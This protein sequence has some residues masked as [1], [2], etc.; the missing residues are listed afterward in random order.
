MLVFGREP[1]CDV[2]IDHPTISARHARLVRV[3]GGMVLEDLGSTNGTF[4]AGQRITR[5]Q[6]ALGAD[7]RIGDVLLPWGD[8]HVASFARKGS[9]SGTMMMSQVPRT[10]QSAKGAAAASTT[11][12][13]SIGVK[14]LVGFVGGIGL[15]I[16]ALAGV[17][18]LST[19][20]G[21]TS[22]APLRS[23]ATDA[24]VHGPEVQGTDPASVMRRTRAPAI[25][26]AMDIADPITRNTAVKLAAGEDG[27]FHVEQVASLWTFVRG[28][29]RYVNDP[30]G[31]E[32]FAKASET[33]TNE[34]AGDCD[35]FAILLA[36]MITAIGGEA[37]VVVMSSP[38][39][40]H[41][42]AEA[43]IRM[44]PAEVASRLATYYRRKWDPYL[45]RQRITR[46]HYRSTEACPVWLNLDWNA[47][48]PGGPYENEQWAV[49]I[50]SDG[51]ST[52]LPP[53]R[54]DAP[55]SGTPT[56]TAQTR[57]DR[58]GAAA[59]AGAASS[60]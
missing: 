38:E 8:P 58:R 42:Y 44:D 25:A 22:S 21:A 53:G 11:A 37:R 33:I 45:G 14:R 23:D 50:A 59:T 35:D 56:S 1:G 15:G 34:Y 13:V 51:A 10:A 30:R 12:G 24:A 49:A 26:A 48:V 27:P 46:V 17:Y 47:G 54:A 60:P 40:G 32:Y 7:V 20:D 31:Q 19:T 36:S 29:W 9:A 39:G 16:G 18:L 4:L 28:R 43:C 52:E 5:A 6:V 55:P 3:R 41:A 2:V 57:P